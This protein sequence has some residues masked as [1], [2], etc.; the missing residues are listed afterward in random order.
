MKMTCEFEFTLLVDLP[1]EYE[2]AENALYEAGCGDALVGVRY[3]CIF[4]NFNREAVS[5]LD[6]IVGAMKQVAD[7][8]LCVR[9]VD[10]CGL[11]TQA[12]IAKRINYSRQAIAYYIKGERGPGGFPPPACYID[13]EQAPLW[14]W[15]EV[16]QWMKDNQ[17]IDDK[18]L[19]EALVIDMINERLESR[20]HQAL[21]PELVKRID[22]Q[23]ATAGL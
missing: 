20:R 16:A 5:L 14:N 17:L 8:K 6:A 18:K 3:G 15:C 1:E 9:R 19:E 2:V 21:N 11:V 22:K 7:A 10:H 4:I 23:V 13:D 12:E